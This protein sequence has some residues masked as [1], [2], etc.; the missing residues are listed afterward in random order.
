MCRNKIPVV[1]PSI[2]VESSAT[3]SMQQSSGLKRS[4]KNHMTCSELTQEQ[5][6][7]RVGDAV[8]DIPQ[9]GFGMLKSK[10]VAIPAD[11]S[12]STFYG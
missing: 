2:E 4:K 9:S 11:F 7:K 8:A 12:P 10:R 5:V 1:R 6:A 3:K